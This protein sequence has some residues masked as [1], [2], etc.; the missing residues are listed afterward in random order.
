MD[1]FNLKGQ[2]ADVIVLH[3]AYAFS[4]KVERHFLSSRTSIYVRA[5]SI[6]GR[7]AYGSYIQPSDLGSD[8]SS[9]C[10]HSD[11][12]SDNNAKSNPKLGGDYSTTYQYHPAAQS[13]VT[14]MPEPFRLS[15]LFRHPKKR[16]GMDSRLG[17]SDSMTSSMVV[18][19]TRGQI[20]ID[21]KVTRRY[22][23]LRYISRQALEQVCRLSSPTMMA[24]VLHI[25]R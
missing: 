24:T 8:I 1:G 5:I 6:I 19:A 18:I 20:E 13:L 25:I 16:Q 22:E 12:I 17:D 11:Q 2:T 10:L 3:T 15:F 14:A 23:N 21:P 7:F 4:E 9:V